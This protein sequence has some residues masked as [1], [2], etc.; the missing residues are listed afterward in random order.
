M[1]Y[2]H[3]ENGRSNM[4][5]T[6]RSQVLLNEKEK[7]FLKK[8]VDEL[9]MSHSLYFKY[10][11]LIESIISGKKDAL[12]SLSSTFKYGQISSLEK[13]LDEFAKEYLKNDG[14]Q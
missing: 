11:M 3:S 9:G 14:N 12:E 2:T 4:A 5:T 8:R 6:S 10:A 13:K 7:K 1:L